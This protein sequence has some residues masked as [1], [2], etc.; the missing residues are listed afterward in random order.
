MCR[1]KFE[2]KKPF[3]YTYGLNIQ[4]R[5]IILDL[6]ML[7]KTHNVHSIQT[8]QKHNLPDDESIAIK[9]NWT[10]RRRNSSKDKGFIFHKREHLAMA[11]PKS[12]KAKRSAQHLNKIIAFEHPT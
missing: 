12:K 3:S 8:I 7:G 4:E 6:K 5:W 10:S 1:R 9:S 11:Y 2:S